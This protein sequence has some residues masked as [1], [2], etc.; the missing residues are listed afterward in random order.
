MGSI[1]RTG[2]FLGVRKLWLTGYTP[3]PPDPRIHKVSLGA[4]QTLPWE[5]VADIL[6]VIRRLKRRKVRVIGLELT[7]GATD[8]A[9][10]RPSAGSAVLLGNEVTGVPP[11]ILSLCDDVVMITRS[12][13]KESLNVSVAAGIA[14]WSLLN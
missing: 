10:Y 14:C 11:S 13:K 5:K 6:D 8:L 12:G 7:G 1:F 3:A 4:E 9:T 2:E